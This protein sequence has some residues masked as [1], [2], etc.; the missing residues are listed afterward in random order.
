[1]SFSF[2]WKIQTFIDMTETFVLRSITTFYVML[3]VFM[4]YKIFHFIFFRMINFVQCME[5]SAF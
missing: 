1:M 5:S 2:H 3:S 4:M